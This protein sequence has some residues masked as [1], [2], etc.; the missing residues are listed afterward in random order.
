[1][2]QRKV[3]IG[4]VSELWPDLKCRGAQCQHGKHCQIPAPSSFQEDL[5]GEAMQLVRE[6]EVSQGGPKQTQ[7]SHRD[8]KN[9]KTVT[10]WSQN[11]RSDHSVTVLRLFH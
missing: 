7:N 8:N 3:T 1:M 2:M 5:R 6:R 10:E 11:S 9:S 4:E